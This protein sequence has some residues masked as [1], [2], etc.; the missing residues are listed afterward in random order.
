MTAISYPLAERTLANGLRVIV[1]EDHTV[2]NVAVNLWVG[3]GSR[4][5]TPGRTGFAHLFE[6]LMFQGSRNVA[7]G[8]HFSALMDEGARLN[9]TTWFD[10]TNYFETVPTGA[11]DLALWLEA[12]RHGHLL[13]AVTQENL[14]N[15]RDVVKEEKRQRYDNVP[16]GSAL[17]DIYAT[18]FPEDHP[19]HHPTIGSMEDLDAATLED[20]HAFFR[21]HYGPNNTVLTLVGDVT[22]EEGFAAA[23]TYFGPLPGHRAAR[24]ASGTRSCRRSPSPCG[25]TASVTCPTTGS[26]SPSGCPVD[27]TPDYLA[28]QVAVDVLGGLA[29]SR[30]VR[31]LVRTDETAVAVGGWTMGLVD[32]VGPRHHHRRR[33]R[34]RRRRAGRGRG[35]RG[36]PSLRRRGAGCRRARVGH[37]RHRALVAERAREHRGASRPHQPP[38]AAHGRPGIRQ[39]VRRAHPRRDRR[40]GTRRRGG[41]ARPAVPRGRPLPR[42]PGHS[43][44]RSPTTRT[45]TRTR[46]RPHD[47]RRPP[48]RRAA[49]AVG[50]SPRAARTTCPT[51]CAC[52]TY[53]VPG[54]YVVSVRL[55]LPVSLRDEPREREGV[56]SIMARTL[57]EGTENHTAEEFARLLERKGVSFGAGMADAG[58]SIDLDVVKGNLEPALD[59]LRQILTEPAFPQAEVARQVRTRIAEIEQERSVAAH[60]AGLE[61]V[62]TFYAPDD[63]SSRPTGGTRETVVVHHPRRRR[64]LP[65]RA[66]RRGGRDRRRRRRPRRP[67]RA[68]ARRGRPWA[69]GPRGPR[70][71]ERH[72]QHAA[73][74]APDRGRIVLVSRPGSVQTEFV[75]GAPGPDRS[76]EGG[77]APYPVLGFVLGGS[78]NARIDAVLREEKGY[79]YGIRSSFRPRRRGGVFLTSGSVRAD[80]T[81]ESLRLLVE[82]LESGR[83]G[84]SDKEIRSGVD[85]IAKTA[86]GRYATADAIADEAV[87][88]A[89]DGR[90]TE[91]SRRPTCAT[92]R[93]STAHASTRRTRGS[94]PAPASAP[95]TPGAGWTIVMVGD[96]TAHLE[97]VRALGL[98]DV[99]VVT[100]S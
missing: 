31:R 88:M 12:D 26:T 95:G 63:R 43:P 24:R 44:S 94:P 85:F 27:T 91:P 45:R 65:R 47:R 22:P 32:G 9:A 39:H 96:A 36:D 86:P 98:G 69:D 16:Y 68:R 57:D 18:V 49:R 61:F 73:A 64:G 93:R 75:I 40:A 19:Y 52:I 58:L 38:R 46:R 7:S 34:R 28:C 20:V 56:A 4:H 59:L 17:I 82:I 66:R 33:V 67:R 48:R 60:R 100:D 42:R 70:D 23:E 5:E 50:R 2:P 77:W 55:G 25:S 92:S 87:G 90:T 83:E 97:A 89:L 3:V 8:E 72:L 84:F 62:R 81:A 71:R 51:G 13:D 1:S 53:D 29:S 79:T 11:L 6:H 41:L 37:R 14:D 10:R 35:V 99:T 15:Q 54:Q 21:A 74:L 80:S 30:L 76:V 78:P